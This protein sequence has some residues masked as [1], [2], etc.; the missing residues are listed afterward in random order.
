MSK[1]KKNNILFL[2]KLMLWTVLCINTQTLGQYGE[3]GGCDKKKIKN[4]NTVK[5]K[6]NLFPLFPKD[7]V[8]WSVI[9]VWLLMW[10]I[11]FCCPQNL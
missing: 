4:K 5:K 10:C 11:L 3:R 8:M 6:A 2:K 7:G 1:S 9:T